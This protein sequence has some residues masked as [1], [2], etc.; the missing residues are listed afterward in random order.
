MF[1][2]CCTAIILNVVLGGPFIPLLT[3][4]RSTRSTWDWSFTGDRSSIPSRIRSVERLTRF[5]SLQFITNMNFENIGFTKLKDTG[6][7]V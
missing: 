4:C 5:F 6:L 2:S 3:T 1:T 7:H